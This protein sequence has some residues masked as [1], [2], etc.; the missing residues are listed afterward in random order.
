MTSQPEECTTA[1]EQMVQRLFFETSF[2]SQLGTLAF[3]RLNAETWSNHSTWQLGA[4]KTTDF[5]VEECKF[6]K[7]HISFSVINSISSFMF[8]RAHLFFLCYNWKNLI[9]QL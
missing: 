3:L 7:I 1:R 4:F 8:E 6:S 5:A 9:S 2:E